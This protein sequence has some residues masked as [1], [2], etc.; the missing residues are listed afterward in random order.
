MDLIT[1]EES[2]GCRTDESW[3]EK[4]LQQNCENSRFRPRTE[5]SGRRQQDQEHESLQSN[6]TVHDEE[7]ERVAVPSLLRKDKKSQMRG[8]N[9]P[10]KNGP[11]L[12]FK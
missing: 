1:L 9:R 5:H 11:F 12:A 8:Q 2:M 7:V 4:F 10:Q 6:F 3:A